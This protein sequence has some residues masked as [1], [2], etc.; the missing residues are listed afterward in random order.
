[1]AGQYDPL[2]TP[3]VILHAEATRCLT[4]AGFTVLI[5]DH[6]CTIDEEI[7]FLWTAP[8]SLVKYLFLVN[9]YI[10]PLTQVLGIY[11]MSRLVTLSDISCRWVI[12]SMGFVETW[13]LSVWDLLLLFR[14]H[15]L[16]GGHRGLVFGTYILYFLAY[17]CHAVV[18]L[19]SAIELVPHIYYD[20][21][22][23]TCV[24][25]NRPSVMAF[26]WI[27][28]LSSETVVFG[29]TM[30][31]VVE[32]RAND[33]T[34]NPLMN[35]L[36]YGQ[37]IYNVVIIAI[38]V[39]NLFIWITL[40][41]SLTFLGVFFI[42]AM[43]TALVTRMM[44]HLR[45]VACSNPQ[46]SHASFFGETALSTQIVWARQPPPLTVSETLFSRDEHPAATDDC[47]NVVRCND[48]GEKGEA[49]A[50]RTF[51]DGKQSD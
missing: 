50:L 10:T 3:Q 44:L 30:V 20:T 18:G 15:A 32:Q 27:F 31:K 22:A 51:V 21:F 17:S 24:A 1:M 35:S 8:P 16:W 42:W 45:R 6:I 19:I 37:V 5:W 38:R 43:I 23:Q 26:E 39:F 49:I 13:S 7:R 25:K 41:P 47:E 34:Y 48:D 2:L 46:Q 12:M 4:M 9:R 33:R 36:H 29:L 11:Y 28:S 14:V 40:P